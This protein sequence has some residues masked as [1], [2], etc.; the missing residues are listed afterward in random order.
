MSA[1]VPGSADCVGWL[2]SV[3]VGLDD[4]TDETADEPGME[5]AVKGDAVDVADSV[6][7]VF[8]VGTEGDRI[9]VRDVAFEDVAD[10]FPEVVR[11][12]APLEIEAG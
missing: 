2:T 1:A 4:V 3:V 9:D 12:E 8:E 10:T 7:V 6:R 5:V 11:F